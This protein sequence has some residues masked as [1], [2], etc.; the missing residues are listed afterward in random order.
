MRKRSVDMNQELLIDSVSI[1]ATISSLF[2]AGIHLCPD[3][4]P[5]CRV[6]ANYRKSGDFEQLEL[7]DF[8]FRFA[9]DGDRLHFVSFKL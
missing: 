1:K 5:V 7:A 8:T 2:K 9:K 4:A 3:L 6:S